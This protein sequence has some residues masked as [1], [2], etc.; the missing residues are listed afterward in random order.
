MRAVRLRQQALADERAK[1]AAKKR[2]EKEAQEKARKNS[3]L[4]KKK[5]DEGG[6]KVGGNEKKL[7]ACD[8]NPMQPWSAGT[9]GYRAQRRTVRR[10]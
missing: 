2:K 5:K 4:Q 10:G 7:N 9:G 6:D 3:V 8:F 1:E